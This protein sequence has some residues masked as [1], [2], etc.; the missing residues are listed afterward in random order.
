MKIL[1]VDDH[2]IVRS[3]LRR[4]LGGERDYEVREA[5]GGRE[6]LAAFREWRPGLVVLDLSMPGI[7]G[8]EVISRLRLEDPMVRILV[9][10]MH[11]EAIYAIRALQA[12]A[13]GFIGKNAPPD[14]LLDAIK[15]LAAG[16]N[17]IDHEI[18]QE[19]ALAAVRAPGGTSSLALQ[20]LSAREFE[21]MRLLG[22]G[23][24]LQ[25]IADAIGISYKTAANC[26]G[27]LKAKLRVARTADLV[28]IA[29]QNGIAGR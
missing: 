14:R 6:A 23:N 29:V 2:P 12:G 5:A 28:R 27:Q 21:I 8:L 9:L 20:D 19:L 26:C 16:H 18:A 3:G 17:Y 10:S 22:D 4:L 1:V 11:A 15:R 24:S 25:Q 7:G 13:A